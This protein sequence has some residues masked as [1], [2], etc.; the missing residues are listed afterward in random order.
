VDKS[1]PYPVSIQSA[2]C[3]LD[4]APLTELSREG[5]VPVAGRWMGAHRDAVPGRTWKQ[6]VRFWS[7]A[8]SEGRKDSY[9]IKKRGRGSRKRE[10]SRR[11]TWRG[12]VT[13]SASTRIFVGWGR[14]SGGEHDGIDRC[15]CAWIVLDE[16]LAL[17]SFRVNIW[18]RTSS[19]KT[20]GE[21]STTPG[22]VR[23]LDAR[24]E[25]RLS[26]RPRSRS[27]H[28]YRPFPAWRQWRPQ[29]ANH[30]TTGISRLGLQVRG[31]PPS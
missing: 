31:P 19:T 30:L 7:S 21:R 16:D 27:R 26:T 9:L 25:S 29:L 14:I 2:S 22:P 12:M 13:E 28:V 17:S 6:V 4:A 15:S 23:P 8:P 3:T 1:F 24:T 20:Y 10:S 11:Q 5:G 18:G